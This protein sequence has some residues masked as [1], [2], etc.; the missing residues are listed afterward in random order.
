MREDDPVDGVVGGV[1]ESVQAMAQSAAAETAT[2]VK[3][4]RD[5]R[6]VGIERRA[7]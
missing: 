3:R 2:A 1:A 6:E 5:L 4:M 7:P